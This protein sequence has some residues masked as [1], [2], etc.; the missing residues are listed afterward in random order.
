M[1]EFQPEGK[2]IDTAAN[3]AALASV[4]SLQEA[5]RSGTVLEARAAVCASKRRRNSTASVR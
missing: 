3:K 4:A 1:T 5:Y 2:I